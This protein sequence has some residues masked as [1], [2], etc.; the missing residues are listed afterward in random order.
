MLYGNA[1]KT[2]LA[3]CFWA[4]A[5]DAQEPRE[6][7]DK[8]EK[9]SVVATLIGFDGRNVSLLKEDG[10]Q[11]S[12]PVT[13]LSVIDREFVLTPWFRDQDDQL[14]RRLSQTF[15][16]DQSPEQVLPVLAAMQIEHPGSPYACALAGVYASAIENNTSKAQALFREA[17]RR[18]K[19]QQEFDEETHKSTLARL[20][21]NLGVSAAKE[22]KGDLASSMF[23]K[24]NRLTDQVVLPI[25][26]NALMLLDAEVSSS[27][28]ISVGGRM[29]SNLASE[30]TSRVYPAV[31]TQDER[32]EK[33]F[34]YTTLLDSPST[35]RATAVGKAIPAMP[36]VFENDT[37]EDPWCIFCSGNG[38]GDC[39][40][41]QCAGGKIPYKKRVQIA[42]NFRGE[43]VFAEKTFY[44]T[45]STCRGV[46]SLR[47]NI[48]RGTGKLP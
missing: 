18:I 31:A 37:L 27:M 9:H 8:T 33:R 45:C 46:G 42:V 4:G 25:Y 26:H 21:N 23:L 29:R 47:C 48:C 13:E 19:I 16:V 2:V 17:E 11:L 7:F 5:V 3:L 15:S 28:A 38:Q 36:S 30:I 32:L 39:S 12:L 1:C 34:V 20:Y 35:F 40:V 24:A 10:Q 14:Y 41:S 43:R 22:K 6:W 44:S